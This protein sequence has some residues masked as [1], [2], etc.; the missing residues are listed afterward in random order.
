MPSQIS[1]PLRLTRLAFRSMTWTAVYPLLIKYLCPYRMERIGQG[2]QRPRLYT[3]CPTSPDPRGLR[4]GDPAWPPVQRHDG[5]VGDAV[6]RTSPVRG[7]RDQERPLHPRHRPRERDLRPERPARRSGRR[8]DPLRGYE[9]RVPRQAPGHPLR[10]DA[11]RLAFS[12]RL[13]GL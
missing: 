7:G 6:L 10:P 13:P 5:L 4:D 3:G 8:R 9:R 2:P 1:G 11:E 12:P